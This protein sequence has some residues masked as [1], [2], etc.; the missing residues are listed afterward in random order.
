MASAIG[1]QEVTA[2]VL[3]HSRR[4]ADSYGVFL[5][6]GAV[7]L[8][9]SISIANVRRCLDPDASEVV[10]IGKAFDGFGDFGWQGRSL[11]EMNTE[12]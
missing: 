12:D 10:P 6:A 11:S 8:I 5:A 9:I 3:S 2:F 4:E 1:V 7:Y